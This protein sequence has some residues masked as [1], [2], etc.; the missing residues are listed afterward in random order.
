MEKEKPKARSE[1]TG[2]D[3][4][5]ARTPLEHVAP[6]PEPHMA[7]VRIL[8]WEG[9]EMRLEVVVVPAFYPS[10]QEVEAGA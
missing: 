5:V 9:L 10:T 4:V 3:G 8:G 2:L 6:K 7:S 1:D